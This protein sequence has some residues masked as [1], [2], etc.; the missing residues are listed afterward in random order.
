MRRGL[1]L[2]AGLAA[3]AVV[4]GAV[5][6]ASVGDDAGPPPRR[7]VAVGTTDAQRLIVSGG[8]GWILD[9]GTA[10]LYKVSAERGQ[11]EATV[12]LGAGNPVD[13]AAGFG[14]IW[15]T[16]NAG[17]RLLR[18]D[19][20]TARIA[21]R[22]RT[23]SAPFGVAAAGGSVWVSDGGTA[24][25]RDPSL[26]RPTIRKIDPA[27]NRTATERRLGSLTGLLRAA[28]DR[29]WLAAGTSVASI[30]LRS[31]RERDVLP[32][33]L[34]GV[35]MFEVGAGRLWLA[36]TGTDEFATTRLINAV[37]GSRRWTTVP[38]DVDVTALGVGAAG[39]WVATAADD[40]LRR[41]DPASGRI[42]QRVR[43]GA[44]LL[45]AVD[46][47]VWELGGSPSLLTRIP[48]DG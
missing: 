41:I 4:A 25:R 17:A 16:D 31:L 15:I 22:I 46:E 1:L 48:V 8:V 35:K 34:D 42:V 14:S 5:V 44:T 38:G 39:A 9:K 45:L 47:D 24:G 2:I 26:A 32:V 19:A 6:V 12:A 13:M 37:P 11:I 40:R 3:T 23:G 30:D 28:G 7:V 27:T 33:P 29:L 18:V 36:G 43:G 20:R 21:A 10:T